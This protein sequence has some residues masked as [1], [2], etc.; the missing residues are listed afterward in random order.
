MPNRKD[1][2]DKIH[3]E[4]IFRNGGGYH[5]DVVVNAYFDM[6]LFLDARVSWV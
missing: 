1:I 5:W 6:R 4:R 2:D 3:M